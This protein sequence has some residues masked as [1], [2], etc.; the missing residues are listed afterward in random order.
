M[1]TRQTVRSGPFYAAAAYSSIINEL[2]ILS[3]NRQS[4]WTH[5][6][7]DLVAK[8]SSI[9][10]PLR[11]A[12]QLRDWTV[13]M[14]TIPDF[15]M[16][17]HKRF[18]GS[19]SPTDIAY[20]P[21][22]RFLAVGLATTDASPWTTIVL[23]DLDTDAEQWLTPDIIPIAKEIGGD[24]GVTSLRFG[25]DD[26]TLF[27]GTRNGLLLRLSLNQSPPLVKYAHASRGGV[28]ARPSADGR[29]CV[30]VTSRQQKLPGQHDERMRCFDATTLEEL[31]VSEANERF[32]SLSIAHTRL[33]YLCRP[34][35]TG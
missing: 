29:Y 8:A 1:V 18:T 11:D 17:I 22:G 5:R 7:L 24:P 6:G 19:L 9:D 4:G 14:L 34:R 10:T 26:D 21:S 20:S 12:R 28:L 16:T 30:T 27:I 15:D 2:N 32:T 3:V 31:G 33:E 13:S 23:V 35:Y 25:Q